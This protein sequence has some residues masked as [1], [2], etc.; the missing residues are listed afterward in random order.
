MVSVFWFKVFKVWDSGV[1]AFWLGLRPGI[2][3]CL[4]QGFGVL[5]FA[6]T[7][8][9]TSEALD[10]VWVGTRICACAG[11]GAESFACESFACEGFACESFACESFAC[12]NFACVNSA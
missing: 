11:F 1:Q 7:W 6:Y 2:L 4:G 8:T 9:P 5:G 10:R 12:K 3:W